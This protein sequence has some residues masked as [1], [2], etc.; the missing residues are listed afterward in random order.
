MS[1]AISADIRREA[2]VSG[3]RTMLM[4]GLLKV[5]GGLTTIEEVLRVTSE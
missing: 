2:V 1:K 4:D 3:M 5:K